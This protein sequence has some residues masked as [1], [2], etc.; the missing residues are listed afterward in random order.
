M[1]NIY[2]AIYIFVLF[3][4]G[5]Y[6]LFP[7][8]QGTYTASG[9]GKGN[10][11][12]AAIEAAQL[13][14]INKMVFTVLRR[15]T[16]YRD[17]FAPEALRNG[18]I[19]TQETRKTP[20]GSWEATLVLEIDE[21]LAEAL[22]VGR[23]ATTLTNLLDQAEEEIPVIEALLQNA[24]RAENEGN[25]GSAETY[26]SQAQTKLEAVLRYLDPVDDAFYFSSRGKRKAAELK[27][28]I[29]SLKE[30]SVKGI[31]R[32]RTAQRQLTIAQSTGQILALFDQIEQALLG[33]E[34]NRDSLARIAASPKGYTKEQLETAAIQCRQQQDAVAVQRKQFIRAT[35]GLEKSQARE[36]ES[37]LVKRASILDLRIQS[38]EK[39]LSSIHGHI[40]AGLLWRSK[41]VS[42]LRWV[43]NHEPAHFISLGVRFPMGIKPGDRGPET[44]SVPLRLALTAEGALPLSAGGGLWG[45]TQVLSGSESLF[46]ADPLNIRQEMALGFF[47]RSVLGLGIRW[48][49]NRKE[50]KPI[51]AIEAVW[52]LPGNSQGQQKNYF[53]WVNTLSWELP[54]E[55]Q[56][57][58]AYVNGGLQS[59]LRPSPALGFELDLSSR[60]RAGSAQ[61]SSFWTGSAALNCTFRL[62]FLRPFAWAVGWEGSIRSP[63][64]DMGVKFEE[65]SGL[66][67]FTFGCTY[68]F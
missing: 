42:A 67:A 43:V 30:T 18:R 21:G 65:T 54:G 29:H 5:S 2:I 11:K 20:L 40:S 13:D 48:D 31:E 38:L 26:Y 41:T 37:Y 44:V 8:S 27:L 9:E 1:K 45:R 58:L 33:I 50:Q 15:D 32:V 24:G 4:C 3:L 28:L 10:S 23:Y 17:L 66:H 49:W 59:I 34:T 68:V 22:Y 55:T 12:E 47:R 52:G 6:S 60:V 57:M 19:I 39:Q 16:L 7:Q 63:L 36:S 56:H 53:L 35:E 51:T 25:L 61:L 14:A 64:T 46:E 62:P